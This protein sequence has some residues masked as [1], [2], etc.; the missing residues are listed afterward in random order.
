MMVRATYGESQCLVSDI[1]HRSTTD[2]SICVYSVR[3]PLHAGVRVVKSLTGIPEEGFDV[4][5][6]QCRNVG[7][8]Q[9]EL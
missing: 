1:A 7:D 8:L 5:C 2:V 4:V 3:Q 6:G 9:Q